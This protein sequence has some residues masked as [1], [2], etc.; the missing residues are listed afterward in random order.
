MHCICSHSTGSSSVPLLGLVAKGAEK[1]SPTGGLRARGDGG[2]QQLVS[3]TS[4]EAWA[5][6]GFPTV[7]PALT[8]VS[9]FLA[10]AALWIWERISYSS[11]G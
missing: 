8:F 1:C 5:H 2:A 11:F 7:G 6:R 10:R 3:A 9:C 4:Q